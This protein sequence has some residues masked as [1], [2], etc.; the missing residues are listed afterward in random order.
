MRTKTLL[1]TAALA[2]LGASSS[3]AQVYSVNAVGYINKSIPSGFSIVANQ[4]NASPDN[5]VGTVFGTPPQDVTL[6]LFNNASGSYDII[7]F[8]GFLGVWDHPEKVVAPGTGVFVYNSGPAYSMT[9]VGEVPQGTLSTPVAH[10]FNL[11][12]SQVPQSGKLQTDLKYIPSAGGGGDTVYRFNNAAG[13]YTINNYIDF[14]ATWDTEPT[15][16]VGEGF[17]IYRG[18]TAAP[19]T[20]TFTVN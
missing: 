19:W 6:Y 13:N 5:T 3:M 7:S 14:L 2:A 18:D 8:I 1:L 10:G 17:F 16:D 4:L 11:V 20:R 12:G 15:P 9:F